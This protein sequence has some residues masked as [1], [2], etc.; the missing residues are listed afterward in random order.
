[1]T[2]GTYV[3]NQDSSRHERRTLTTAVR[4][5]LLALLRLLLTSNAANADP[6]T[7]RDQIYD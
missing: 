7:W 2:T 5:L 6:S 3:A 1:M 4:P